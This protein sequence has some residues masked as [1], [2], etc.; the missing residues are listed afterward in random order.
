MKLVRHGQPGQE[1]PGIIDAQGQIRDLSAHCKDFDAAFFAADGLQ[2]LKSIDTQSLPVVAPGT[3]LGPCVGQ[4]GLFLAIGLN[5]VQHAIETNAP[6]PTDPIIFSKAPSCVS[7][8]SDPV[9]LPKGSTKTDWEVELAFVVGKRAHYVAESEALDYIAGYFICNDVSEREFQLERSGQ[10]QKGKMCPT[11]GPIGPW[12]VTSDEIADVQN[13][14]L[15]LELNGKRI[16][17]SST[18]DMI[19]SI[20]KILADVSQ[21][22]VL[23]PGD[24]ITT[25][26]PPGV[27]LGMKPEAYLKPGDVMRL[28]ID[29]LGVQEQRVLRWGEQ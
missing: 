1:R 28:G 8:P 15:W 27:G 24:I 7:G 10:W 11:F 6:I 14:G 13:L 23:Q 26:T 2:S 20:A 22:V 9:L 12:L 29:G 25:G 19:F 17:D 5:Y 21:Y 18:S 16:Q 3:R 4:P